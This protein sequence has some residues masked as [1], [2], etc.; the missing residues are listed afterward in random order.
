MVFSVESWIFLSRLGHVLCGYQNDS[1]TLIVPFFFFT[2][3]YMLD[4]VKISGYIS[5]GIKE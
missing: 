1:K 3:W 5:S 4:S 2:T